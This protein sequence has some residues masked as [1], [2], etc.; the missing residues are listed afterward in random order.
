M[1]DDCHAALQST[2][3]DRCHKKGATHLSCVHIV[4]LRC[5]EKASAWWED[6][7]AH[8]HA[9]QLNDLTPVLIVAGVAPEAFDTLALLGGRGVVHL[10]CM[11]LNDQEK[12]TSSWLSICKFP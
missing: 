5:R 12:T 3:H 9:F 11:T 7:L 8:T 4:E 6:Y 2:S 1:L 10:Q